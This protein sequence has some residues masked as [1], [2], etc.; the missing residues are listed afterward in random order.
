MIEQCHY[1]NA[2]FKIEFFDDYKVNFCPVCGENL[3][4]E[5]DFE[6]D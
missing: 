4:I 3:D 6:N 5:L 1:C 2:E